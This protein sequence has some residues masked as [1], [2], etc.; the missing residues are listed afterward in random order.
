MDHNFSFK[1]RRDRGSARVGRRPEVT[2]IPEY[3][4][5]SSSFIPLLQNNQ[6]L[7][8]LP[9]STPGNGLHPVFQEMSCLALIFL[10][11]K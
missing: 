9:T 7:S 1:T 4:E 11:L 10:V 3:E 5:D 8:C 2:K 6:L